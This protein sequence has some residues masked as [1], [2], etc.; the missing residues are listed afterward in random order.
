MAWT[1][2]VIDVLKTPTFPLNADCYSNQGFLNC[3][4][5]PAGDTASICQLFNFKAGPMLGT[6]SRNIVCNSSMNVSIFAYSF[7]AESAPS[8][9]WGGSFRNANQ[10]GALVGP[11]I[12][13]PGR[14]NRR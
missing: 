11:T 10:G 9:G 7:A 14:E 4:R 8:A 6:T 1:D 13:L 3:P 12:A 5:L 2:A